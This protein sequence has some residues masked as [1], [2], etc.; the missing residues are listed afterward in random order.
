MKSLKFICISV[1]CC[2]TFCSCGMNNKTTPTHE[3]T[4]SPSAEATANPTHDNNGSVVDDLGNVVEDAG[5]A[6]GDA[7]QNMGDAVNDVVGDGQDSN[8]Q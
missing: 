6:V 7:A 4:S 5:D 1:L 8:K 3:P 2:M